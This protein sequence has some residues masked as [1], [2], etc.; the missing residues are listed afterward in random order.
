MKI[1][2][3]NI[4]YNNELVITDIDDC[5]MLT[6]NSIKKHKIRIKSFYKNIAINNKYKESVYMNAELTEWGK[7]FIKLVSNSVI[8][9]YKLITSAG[10]RMDIICK[11]FGVDAYY[12][13]ELVS[14]KDKVIYLNDLNVK[15]IYIDDK[16][17]VL[18]KITNSNIKLI[19]YPEK[20]VRIV[21]GRKKKRMKRMR[22]L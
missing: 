8:K 19:N 15:A 16:V 4:E 13:H 10:N 6:T 17:I 5:L 22:V 14:N 9:N 1:N 3:L 11:K 18:N 21:S 2:S 20:S 7:E 12:V